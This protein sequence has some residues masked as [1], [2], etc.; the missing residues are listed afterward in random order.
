MTRA[1]GEGCRVVQ[2]TGVSSQ[3][4]AFW[5]ALKRDDNRLLR[6]KLQP[7]NRHLTSRGHETTLSGRAGQTPILQET[8][9][10]ITLLESRR[11]PY[12]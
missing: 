10:R 4:K 1:S 6:K 12:I 11:R 8:I 9:P 2:S 5:R 7:R 3:G